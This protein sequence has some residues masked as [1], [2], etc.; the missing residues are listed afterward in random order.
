MLYF[1]AVVLIADIS[2]VFAHPTIDKKWNVLLHS[3]GFETARE[4]TE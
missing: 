1:F 2:Q 4:F 3:I